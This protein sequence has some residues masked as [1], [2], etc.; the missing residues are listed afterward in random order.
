MLTQA[1]QWTIKPYKMYRKS[2]KDVN[3]TSK[4][5]L[6]SY[7][8]SSRNIC[9][10][11][12]VIAFAY[13]L[14]SLGLD[15][16]HFS[17]PPSSQLREHGRKILKPRPRN[18]CSATA[19]DCRKG[20]PCEIAIDPNLTFKKLF[21]VHPGLV[22]SSTFPYPTVY[23]LLCSVGIG[24]PLSAAVLLSILTPGFICFS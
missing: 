18:S 4:L 1:F 21:D 15:S 13:Q 11:S 20:F 10:C 9:P 23:S 5:V 19:I 8:L 6:G 24:H 17:F 14:F 7:T 3:W 2:E 22:P 12:K 16:L